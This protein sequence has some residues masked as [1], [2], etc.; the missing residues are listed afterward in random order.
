[1]LIGENMKMMQRIFAASIIVVS[2]V[3]PALAQEA[4]QDPLDRKLK[5]CLDSKGAETNAGMVHCVSQAADDWDKR[6]NQ[7]YGSLMKDLDPASRNL[8]LTAQRSWVDYRKKDADFASGPWR[9]ST[10]TLSQ[11]TIANSRLGELRARVL[12]LE[13]YQRGD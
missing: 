12:T 10:G 1:M 5:V 2:L 11:L 8:L 3:A 13:T 7:V 6:L 9:T 4:A